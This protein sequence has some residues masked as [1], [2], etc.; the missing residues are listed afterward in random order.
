MA[1]F[2][3]VILAGNL[4]RDPELRYTPRGTAVAKLGLAVNRTFKT[5]SG[6]SK[7]EVAFIDVEAFGRQAEVL[8]QYLRKGRPILM[9]GRLRY[10][11]WD[12]KQSGAKRSKLSVVL[13]SFTFLDSGKGEGQPADSAAVRTAPPAPQAPP[14]AANHEADGPAVE[15][16]DVPF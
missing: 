5:E 7:D 4:T 8:S 16:D 10:D 11:T 6:E 12:D 3:K 13:E 2:N 14:P 9:E 1:S 15:D